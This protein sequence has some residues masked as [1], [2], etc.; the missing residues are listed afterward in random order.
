[1]AGDTGNRAAS[2]PGPRR[3]PPSTPTSFL[4]RVISNEGARTRR[5][6][7]IGPFTTEEDAR[8]YADRIER[9]SNGTVQASVAPMTAP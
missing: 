1:M 6:H 9:S 3:R 7:Y 5:T 4:V 2:G 8:R